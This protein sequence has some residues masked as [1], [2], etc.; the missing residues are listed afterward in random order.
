MTSKEKAE[1][2]VD[3]QTIDG[4]MRK[5]SDESGGHFGFICKGGER[6]FF[7]GGRADLV[8]IHIAEAMATLV[9]VTP[10]L[11]SEFIDA[12]CFGA[13]EIYAG[14]GEKEKAQ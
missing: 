13:K 6:Q 4:I 14:S 2:M 11:T 3:A 12:V 5:Y 7:L 10:G 1:F 9:N 8:A